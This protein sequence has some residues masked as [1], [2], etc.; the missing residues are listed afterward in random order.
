MTSLTHIRPARPG[1]ETA[2]SELARRSKAFWGYPKAWLEL[3]ESSLRIDAQ[4]LQSYRVEVAEREGAILG[5]YILAE[6][7]PD[8][9]LDA[10]WVDPDHLRKG[11]GGLLLRRAMDRAREAGAA[12]LFIDSDPHVTGFYEA[13]GARQIGSVPSLPEGRT[14]PRLELPL[15]R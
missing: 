6:S 7:S 2:L 9:E 11:V 4:K 8:A 14:L 10:L 12:R 13:H 5:L 3:W 1:E 15:T